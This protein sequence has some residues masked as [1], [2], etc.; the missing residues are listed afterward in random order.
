M[1]NLD[2]STELVR[3]RDYSNLG[4]VTEPRIH[5]PLNDLPSRGNEFIEFCDR[6]GHPLLPWQ[7]WL[8]HHSL[9]V[10]PDGTWK[11]P[12]V[13]LIVARQNGKS[14]Y[15]ALQIL[16][17]IYGLGERGTSRDVI[18]QFN[19]IDDIPVEKAKLIGVGLDFG[20]TNDPTSL[21]EVWKHEDNL[22]LN[23]LLYD[24]GMTNQDIAE[25]MKE[26]NVDRFIDIIAD[27][28]EPKSVEEISRMGFNIKPAQKG[29]DSIK[30]GIDILK[31]HKLH[32]TKDSI[33]L[34][35]EFNNY[36]WVTDK[37]GNK[38]NKPIDMFNHALD[39]VRYVALNKLKTK[40]SGHYNIRII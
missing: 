14:T 23:E 26:Y 15:M 22:Y 32:V 8:A 4:G 5:T 38:L 34:I 29:P 24:K 21:I 17:R 27:S 6:I 18:F 16:W 20:F 36:K 33:N 3:V 9:K 35:K 19:E 2:Q 28:A 30:N 39:A 25:A 37:D 7:Q 40:Y 11:H 13:G 12:I 1:D 31:R 10:N